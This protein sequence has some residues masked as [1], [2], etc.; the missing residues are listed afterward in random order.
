[1]KQLI[2][3]TLPP[4]TMSMPFIEMPQRALAS[5]AMTSSPPRPEAPADCEALPLDADDAAHHVLADPGAAMAAHGD[6]RLPVHAAAVIA[7][8]ALDRDLDGQSEADR[9]R[10]R[11]LGIDDPPQALVG[12]PRE[13]VQTAVE[14][15]H[16]LAAEVELDHAG[17]TDAPRNRP[18]PGAVPRS[19]HCRRRAASRW[20]G[21]RSPSPPNHRSHP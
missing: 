11:A 7:G 12:V 6:G 19:W 9:D 1:M 5:P 18:S 2:W 13:L 3:P 21:T 4:T 10:M 20:R 16:R 15:P 8:M 17:V 14:R